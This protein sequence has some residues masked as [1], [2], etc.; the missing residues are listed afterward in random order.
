MQKLRINDGVVNVLSANELTDQGFLFVRGGLHR[1]MPSFPGAGNG[2]H[3]AMATVENQ[4]DGSTVVHE[5][6]R[7]APVAEPVTGP[8]TAVPADVRQRFG[9][10]KVGAAFF[11]WLVAVG[12]TVRLSGLVAL[13]V[14]AWRPDT[15]SDPTAVGFTSMGTAIAVLAI[16]F[17]TGGYVAGRLARFDG[18]RNGLLAWL[19]GLIVT[20]LAGIAAAVV[21]A[22]TDLTAGIRLPAMPVDASTMT[23]GGAVLLAVTVLVTALA[24]ALGGRL[25]ERFHR[26]VD[27]AAG[28]NL[29]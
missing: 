19:L 13:A 25:G 15:T 7:E 3:R 29:R 14:A 9:G 11:G 2:E 16:A 4:Q 12:M 18:A 26:R 5:P 20:V 10:A 17:L 27:R 28:L 6:V 23:V 22:N 24:A 1:P 21:G 8:L